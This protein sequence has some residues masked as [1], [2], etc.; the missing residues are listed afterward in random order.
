MRAAACARDQ[1]GR[2]ADAPM[3]YAASAAEMRSDRHGDLRVAAACH[4]ET[5]PSGLDLSP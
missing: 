3:V 1:V 2:H 5:G 4:T